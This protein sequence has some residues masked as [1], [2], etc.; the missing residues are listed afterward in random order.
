MTKVATM[1]VT[2][3]S[4]APHPTESFVTGES[5]NYMEAMHHQ[6]LKDPASVHVSWDVFFKN[7]DRNVPAGSAFSMPPNLATATT[8]ASSQISLSSGGESSDVSRAINLITAYQRRGH[9]NAS[10]DP[11]GIHVPPVIPELDPMTYG[12]KPEDSS[13]PLDLSGLKVHSSV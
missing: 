7:V 11:L 2:R 5:I 6:W 13:R 10:L 9:E 4:S 12:F 8:G 1:P 3:F